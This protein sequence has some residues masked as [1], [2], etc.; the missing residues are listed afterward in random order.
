MDDFGFTRQVCYTQNKSVQ[1]IIRMDSTY[2]TL[3]SHC[4]TYYHGQLFW[5]QL[6][7]NIFMDHAPYN[8]FSSYHSL[9]VELLLFMTMPKSFTFIVAENDVET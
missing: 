5:R 3:Q 1:R 6:T 8:N 9:H 4:P 2:S 7:I